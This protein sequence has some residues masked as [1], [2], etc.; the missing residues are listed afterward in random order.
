MAQSSKVNKKKIKQKQPLN[1]IHTIKINKLYL[2]H[3][4]HMYITKIQYLPNKYF[5]QIDP[6]KDANIHKIYT[7]NAKYFY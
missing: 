1:T 2:Y 5:I 6:S 4:G 7:L 3:P